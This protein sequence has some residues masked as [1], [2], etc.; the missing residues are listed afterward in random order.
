MRWRR[1]SQESAILL[2]HLAHYA[3]RGPGPGRM[4]P[5]HLL[6]QAQ[7]R[8]TAR[9]SSLNRS[10]NG[11]TSSAP[12]PQADRRRWWLLMLA[13]PVPPPDSTTSGTACP[14]K[15]VTTHLV[16][17]LVGRGLGRMNSR[18][19]I[20]RFCSGRYP[21]QGVEEP[22]TGV[23]HHQ[24]GTRGS[25]EIALHL[26]DLTLPQ[27]PVVDERMEPVADRTLNQC[28]GHGRIDPAGQSADRPSRPICCGD[29]ADLGVDDPSVD[30]L[31][32]SP[33]TSYRKRC[34]MA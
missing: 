5:D 31:A 7:C 18:P 9:T 22:L 26:L 32:V 13:V 34:R 21:C 19:M 30:Q 23:H 33:A 4:A 12:G 3:D 11:S 14:G 6:R 20:L 1:P 8:A 28:R 17:H 29:R 16:D 10:R 2:G 15:R 25:D 24:T 27:Q